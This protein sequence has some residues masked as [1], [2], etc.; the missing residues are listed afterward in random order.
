MDKY[1]NSK[2]SIDLLNFFGLKLPCE[3]KYKSLEEFQKAFDKGMDETAN[4]KKNIKDVANYEKDSLTGLILAFPKAGENSREKT[5]ELIRE[6]N[7]MQIFINNMGQLR[8]YKKNNRNWYY[9]LQQP[10]TTYSQT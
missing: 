4:L 3:Y 1:L 2:E 5:K 6:Y 8:N 10:S 7:I 9:P